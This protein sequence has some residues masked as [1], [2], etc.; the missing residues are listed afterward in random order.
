[1]IGTF[2]ALPDRDVR[3][4]VAG[5]PN[6]SELGRAIRAAAGEDE[7]IILRLEFVPDDDIQ[8]YLKAADLV[9]LPF[10][11]V[12]NSASA[13]LAL[14][15]DRPVLVP[16]RGSMAELQHTVGADWV[17]V[18]PGTLDA[19]ELARS[20]AWIAEPR[21]PEAP[22]DPYDWPAIGQSTADA[23]KRTRAFVDRGRR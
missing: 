4:V 14:S 20:L 11:D 7:R 23:Y 9:A 10:L 5:R 8:V 21:A 2:R 18:Y 16:A 6:S 19:D 12:L 3:L 1:L 22:L 17:R 13:L 15:F